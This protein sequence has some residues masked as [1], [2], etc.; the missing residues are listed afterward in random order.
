MRA[1]EQRPQARQVH[2]N[3]RR[4][5]LL[6]TGTTDTGSLCLVRFQIISQHTQLISSHTHIPFTARSEDFIPTSHLTPPRP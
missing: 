2:L 6:F 3:S 4:I 1:L 5:F